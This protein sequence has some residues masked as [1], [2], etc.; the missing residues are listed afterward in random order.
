[1]SFLSLAPTTELEAVNLMLSS[2]GESAVADLSDPL[3]SDALFAI[4]CLSTSNRTL[5]AVGW[6]F[7]TRRETWERLVDDTIVVPTTSLSVA[8]T[9]DSKGIHAVVSAGKLYDL[10]N[11][12]FVWTQDLSVEVV[13]IVPF[14]DLPQAARDYIVEDA[15][16]RFQESTVGSEVLYKFERDRLVR[17]R[18]TLMREQRRSA[19]PN[20]YTDSLSVARVKL[21]RAGAFIRLQ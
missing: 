7:N 16:L 3:N 20:M 2:I 17:Y 19:Q 13:Y 12:T 14:T 8:T 6:F 1:M 10:D 5:Q 21:G 4:S 9:G 11:N 15:G 18:G